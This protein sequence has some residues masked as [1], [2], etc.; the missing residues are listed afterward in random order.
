MDSV[1]TFSLAPSLITQRFSSF[2][3]LCVIAFHGRL[4]FFAVTQIF[5]KSFYATMKSIWVLRHRKKLALLGFSSS[6]CWLRCNLLEDDPFLNTKV[7]HIHK[8]IDAHE[9][10]VITSCAC[11]DTYRKKNVLLIDIFLQCNAALSSI[12]V[13]SLITLMSTLC[14]QFTCNHIFLFVYVYVYVYVYSCTKVIIIQINA[15][16]QKL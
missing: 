9:F 1:S 2:L 10:A 13:E 6:F 11:I 3:R 5:V 12:T 8:Y 16:V 4:A 14:L 15:Y 7:V